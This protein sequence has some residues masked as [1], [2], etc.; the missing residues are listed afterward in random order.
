MHIWVTMINLS[1][2]SMSKTVPSRAT[3]KQQQWHC[4]GWQWQQWLWQCQQYTNHKYMSL[5]RMWMWHYQQLVPGQIRL[6]IHAQGWQ[7]NEESFTR[8]KFNALFFCGCSIFLALFFQ[9]LLEKL[10]ENLLCTFCRYHLWFTFKCVENSFTLRRQQQKKLF[11]SHH[12]V[13]SW[14]G[15][16]TQLWQQW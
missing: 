9:N 11:F 15:F 2:N 3:N 7:P 1:T 5:K 4:R 14:N 8:S 12:S 13:L 6:Y 10:L 16:C